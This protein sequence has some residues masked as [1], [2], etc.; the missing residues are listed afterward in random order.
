MDDRLKLNGNYIPVDSH[1]YMNS[2]TNKILLIRR[3]EKY[4]FWVIISNDGNETLLATHVR[5]H[6]CPHE[7]SK[8]WK[9]YNNK[10]RKYAV[11]NVFLKKL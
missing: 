10:T 5:N 8:K 3:K 1:R 6:Y 7:E 9:I 11:R 4:Y 2:A